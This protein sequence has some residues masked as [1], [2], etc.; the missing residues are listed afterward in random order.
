MPMCRLIIAAIV[1]AVAALTRHRAI[2][3]ED[4]HRLAIA[5]AA[6]ATAI[7]ADGAST[8]GL[9]AGGRLRYGYGF[10]NT[11]ELGVEAGAFAGSNFALAGAELRDGAN[12]AQTGTLWTDALAVELTA[13]VRYSPGISV[14]RWFKDTHPLV[15]L[16]LG[17]VGRL[18]HHQTLIDPMRDQTILM[19]SSDLTLRPLAGVD[20]GVERRFGRALVLGLAVELSY[21]GATYSGV[22]VAAECSWLWY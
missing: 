12:L 9:G 17:L 5:G 2:A 6:Q 8:S 4:E 20:L 16:R 1:L 22:T 19:P 21:A 13:D 10:T 3:E 18:L 14:S 7:G 15:G 11:L